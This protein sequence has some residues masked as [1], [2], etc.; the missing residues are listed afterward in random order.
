MAEHIDPERDDRVQTEAIKHVADLDPDAPDP[1]EAQA[2]KR[3]I[4]K[5]VQEARTALTDEQR[6]ESTEGLT[7]QLT[8]LVVAR[9]ARSVSCYIPVHSEPDTR[10][11]IAWAHTE[12]IELLMPSTRPDGLLDWV[13]DSGEGT[14]VGAFGIPEPLG[15]HLSPIAVSEVDL[16]LVPACAVDEQGTRLGWGRGYF[17][18]NLGSMDQRPPVF[19]IVNDSEVLES[20]PDE[21]HD[22]PVTGAVTPQRIL[23]FDR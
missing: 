9:G 21:L 22:V 11:F 17:D 12:G 3:A 15:E 23:H 8:N 1:A 10:P 20:L 2:A 14:V 18:R 4:R 7:E 13:R 19:A 5:A 6:A 16:M